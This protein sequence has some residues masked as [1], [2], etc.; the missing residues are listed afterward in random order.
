MLEI[1]TTIMLNPKE[2]SEKPEPFEEL[3]WLERN[4][5]PLPERTKEEEEMG[6][7]APSKWKKFMERHMPA[8]ISERK[9]FRDIMRNAGK[10]EYLDEPL[11]D[12]IPPGNGQPVEKP[13]KAV[14]GSLKLTG[15]GVAT[16]CSIPNTRDKDDFIGK[17][18]DNAVLMSLPTMALKP[19]ETLQAVMDAAIKA[20]KREMGYG[21]TTGTAVYYDPINQTLDLL[22]IG[23]SRVF[24]NFSDGKKAL[25]VA[26]TP[27]YNAVSLNQANATHRRKADIKLTFPTEENAK[28]ID[29]KGT[30]KL[31]ELAKIMCGRYGLDNNTLQA[32]LVL[33]SDGMESLANGKGTKQGTSLHESYFSDLLNNE[34]PAYSLATGGAAADFEA[35]KGH[36]DDCTVI[37]IPLPCNHADKKEQTPLLAFMADGIQAEG[38]AYSRAAVK[39]AIEA[40]IRAAQEVSP[41]TKLSGVTTL[42]PTDK[43]QALPG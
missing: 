32:T 37:A 3:E 20:T 16:I 23:D 5:I 33:T 29:I 13:D 12:S 42:A 11:A 36:R 19:E 24:L 17:N 28:S 30:V 38:K 18:S 31:E 1:I 9:A 39:A 4:R 35:T 10:L 22:Q 6:C 7:I 15:G 2:E 21:G 43:S 41:A 25:Y 14:K 34:H 40:T 26:L 8:I 27:I